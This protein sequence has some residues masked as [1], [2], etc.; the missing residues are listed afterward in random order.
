MNIC[1]AFRTVS[2]TKCNMFGNI[3]TNKKICIKIIKFNG[4]DK[5]IL[6]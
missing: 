2:G 4:I 6:Q 3:Q 1:K 5:Y